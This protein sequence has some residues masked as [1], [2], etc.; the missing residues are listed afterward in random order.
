M[1]GRRSR[2]SL[3]MYIFASG[4]AVGRKGSPGFSFAGFGGSGGKDFATAREPAGGD[5]VGKGHLAVAIRT[6]YFVKS[7]LIFA[8]SFVGGWQAVPVQK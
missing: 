7:S 2:A 4:I 3:R 6:A 1:A 8:T 5:G